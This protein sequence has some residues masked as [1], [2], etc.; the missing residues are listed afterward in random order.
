VPIPKKLFLSHASADRPFVN[1]LATFLTGRKIP[2]WYSR[3]HLVGAQQWH[4]EI[5]KALQSCDWFLVVISPAA[6]RSKWVKRELMYAL[7]EDRYENRIIPMLYKP[8]DTEA[9]SWTLA[10]LQRVD[11]SKNFDQS[12]HE[13]IKIW[14]RS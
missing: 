12:C 5:G 2:F 7:N 6:V 13:L 9:L 4:D 3:R 14:R 10:S 11:F 1:K 8:C